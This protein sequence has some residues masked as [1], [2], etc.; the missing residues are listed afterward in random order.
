MTQSVDCP[1][2]NAP[3]CNE[4]KAKNPKLVLCSYCGHVFDMPFSEEKEVAVKTETSK[5]CAPTKTS[6]KNYPIGIVVLGTINATFCFCDIF[7]EIFNI[8]I[9]DPLWGYWIIAISAMG[10]VAWGMAVKRYAFA[11]VFSFT[12]MMAVFYIWLPWYY[13]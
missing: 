12:L 11:A 10:L 9:I 8:T 4:D 7:R 5:Q 1:K 6:I 3:D 2:C 13:R